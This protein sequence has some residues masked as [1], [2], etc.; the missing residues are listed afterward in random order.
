M[1]D[2][3]LNKLTVNTG[4]MEASCLPCLHEKS[5]FVTV[6]GRL[7]PDDIREVRRNELHQ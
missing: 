6:Y 4:F 5:T 2:I 1:A 7:Y 3:V